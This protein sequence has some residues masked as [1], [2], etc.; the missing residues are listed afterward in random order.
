MLY[1][2]QED[3]TLSKVIF[4]S[5]LGLHCMQLVMLVRY[6]FH[7]FPCLLRVSFFHGLLKLISL[8]SLTSNTSE[9]TC[10]YTISRE[11]DMLMLLLFCPLANHKYVW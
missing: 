7:F 4:W 9:K 1:E 3:P 10:N 11:Y 6:E 8:Y 5:L 2:L